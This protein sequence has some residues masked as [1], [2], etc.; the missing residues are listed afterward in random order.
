MRS[1]TWICTEPNLS[2]LAPWG[3]GGTARSQPRVLRVWLHVVA[4][5]EGLGAQAAPGLLLGWICLWLPLPGS[6]W[7][8]LKLAKPTA[9]VQF[10]FRE[11]AA[12]QPDS[13][14]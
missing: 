3:Q 2:A 10:W 9:P 8:M 7:P 4:R 11:G 12:A 6:V 5:R 13:L 1:L 14:L